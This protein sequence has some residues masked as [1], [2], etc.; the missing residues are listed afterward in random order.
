MSGSRE[1][2]RL[3]RDTQS[4]DERLRSQIAPEW[5]RIEI[6]LS[7]LKQEGMAP[8]HLGIQHSIHKLLA[9][10]TLSVFS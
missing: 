5:K 4:R 10:E 7:K 8:V 9:L 3:K 1:C 6:L 2:V